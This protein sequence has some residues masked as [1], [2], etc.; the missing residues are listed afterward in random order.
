MIKEETQEPKCTCD[1][2]DAPDDIGH[3]KDCPME[4]ELT[5]N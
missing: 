2:G 1:I 5:E 4:Q 3:F